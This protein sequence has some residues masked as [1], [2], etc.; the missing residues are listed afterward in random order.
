MGGAGEDELPRLYP[1]V[2]SPAHVVPDLRR[3]LP[4]VDQSRGLAAED[5][6]RIKIRRFPS[7]GVDVE[8]NLAGGKPPGRL[9]LATCLG[10]LDEARSASSSLSATRAT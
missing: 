5:Q 6:L 1:F 10:A 8:Q 2:N 9:G 3:D 4:L 7:R